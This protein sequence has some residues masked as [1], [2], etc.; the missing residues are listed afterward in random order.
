MSENEQTGEF[1][2]DDSAPD[3]DRWTVLYEENYE[4]VKRYFARRVKCT[5]DVEDLVQN[6]FTGLLGNYSHI[7][8]PEVYVR[9]VARHELFAYWRRRRRKM[10]IAQILPQGDDGLASD[11]RSH[12][13]E[14]D[15]LAHLLSQESAGIAHRLVGHLT[16]ALREAMML[17]FLS[18]LPPSEAAA[19]AGC[20]MEAMKK[21]VMRA[22]ETLVEWHSYP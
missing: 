14:S 20:S 9:I 19:R 7:E 13:P 2:R 11:V 18:G 21:R 1:Q 16:P 8:K 3:Y 6:V 4:R 22:R 17:R 12:N 5:Q 10:L 15:P